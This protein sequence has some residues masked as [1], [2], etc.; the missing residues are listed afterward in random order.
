MI[1]CKHILFSYP[2]G[3]FELKI[4]H[5]EINSNEQVAVIGPSGTGKTTFLY[6]L[7]GIYEANQGTVLIDD[8]VLN[9]YSKAERQDFRIASMG[10][11]FQEFELLEYLTV[12]DNVLLPYY[13]NS[14]MSKDPQ[15]RERAL[16]LIE[17]TGLIAK[18]T[19]YPHQ[20]SQGERQRVAVCRALIT[21]PRVL[22][23]DEPTGNLDPGN[24]DLVLNLLLDY[25][26]KQEVPLI[27]VTHDHQ[28]LNRFSRV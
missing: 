20:L 8:I 2:Q 26:Q 1:V 11:V 7:A 5:L 14:I 16:D 10:L 15:V 24:R 4:P 28:P 23:C 13:I 27:L 9:H 3:S 12:E 25:S 22:L 17:T 18:R 19:R 6:L 21:Q